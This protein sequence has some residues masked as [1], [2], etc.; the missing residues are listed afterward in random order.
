MQRREFLT[1]LAVAPL[2]KY[3]EQI[4]PAESEPILNATFLMYH[5]V[6]YSSL[7]RDLVDFLERG[8]V[9][10]SGDA[11]IDLFD[12]DLEDAKKSFFFVTLDDGR[13]SQYRAAE[14]VDDLFKESGIFI[15]LTFFVLTKFDD[16]T[17][18]LSDVPDETPSYQDDVHQFM[19]KGEIIDLIKRGHRVENHTVNHANLPTL[20]TGARN[21]EVEVGEERIRALWR[22]AGRERRNKLFSYPYG[23]YQNQ[24]EYVRSLGY[25][26]AFSTIRSAR[27]S[28]QDR[29]TLGRVGRS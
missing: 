14:V 24:V 8:H 23:S 10:L 6:N 4:F 29:Y 17:E 1:L 28:S 12:R 15:P 16:F 7:K 3:I 13:R 18:E 2:A 22:I 20:P 26:L 27:H 25:S 11:L 5:E 9:P 19:R 21:A